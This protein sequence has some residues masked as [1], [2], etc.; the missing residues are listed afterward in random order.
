[1]QKILAGDISISSLRVA[2][3]NC[4]VCSQSMSSKIISVSAQQ[5]ETYSSTTTLFSA[6]VNPL[7]NR[8]NIQLAISAAKDLKNFLFILTPP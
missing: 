1:M 7:P 4:I 8:T 6:K 3:I 2:A 5:P